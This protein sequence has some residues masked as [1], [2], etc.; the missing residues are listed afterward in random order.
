LGN[1]EFGIDASYRFLA[2]SDTLSRDGGIR[3]G[4]FALWRGPITANSFAHYPASGG[5]GS[6]G[7]T[8]AGTSPTVPGPTAPTLQS[9][10]YQR[11]DIRGH[12]LVLISSPFKQVTYRMD[13]DPVAEGTYEINGTVLIIEYTMFFGD[14]GLRNQLQ[15]KKLVYNITSN[16][17]FSGNGQSWVR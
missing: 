3:I 6:L 14:S 8:G 15:G 5:S 11:S 1:F 10:T 9:G 7:S 2:I 16:S 4:L 13:G 17:T 12:E